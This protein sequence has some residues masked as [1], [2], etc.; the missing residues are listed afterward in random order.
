[1]NR[2]LNIERFGEKE[3]HFLFSIQI[4][5]MS[6][7][8]AFLDLLGENPFHTTFVHC[9]LNAFSGRSICKTIRAMVPYSKAISDIVSFQEKS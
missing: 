1:M 3:S 6:K 9:V 5:M 4:F 2:Y 8:L 7:K